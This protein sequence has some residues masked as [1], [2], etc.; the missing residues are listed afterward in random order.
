[1]DG[2]PDVA[3]RLQRDRPLARGAGVEVDVEVDVAG[4]REG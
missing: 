4:K 3:R 2:R 1:M